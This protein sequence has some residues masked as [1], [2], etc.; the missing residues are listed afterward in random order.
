MEEKEVDREERKAK[1]MVSEEKSLVGAKKG[2]ATFS[3]E[4]NS[5]LPN[6]PLNRGLENGS[7][8][9]DH[10]VDDRE[11]E[12]DHNNND[13]DDDDDARSVV[14]IDN[15]VCMKERGDWVEWVDDSEFDADGEQLDEWVVDRLGQSKWSG[16]EQEHDEFGTGANLLHFE[17][18]DSE[19]A[20]GNSDIV[21]GNGSVA[22]QFSPD[23]DFLPAAVGNAAEEHSDLPDPLFDV[24][25]KGEDGSAAIFEDSVDPG[26]PARNF[27]SALESDSEISENGLVRNFFGEDRDK[28]RDRPRRSAWAVS[29]ADPAGSTKYAIVDS[30][31]GSSMGNATRSISMSLHSDKIVGTQAPGSSGK[32]GIVG[33]SLKRWRKDQGLRHSESMDEGISSVADQTS[34]QAPADPGILNNLMSKLSLRGRARSGTSGP[35][36]RRT[37]S[38]DVST[39]TSED[40]ISELE[41]ISSD[42]PSTVQRTQ[43][44]GSKTLP[45]QSPRRNFLKDAKPRSSL[46]RSSSNQSSQPHGGSDSSPSL[47]ECI[48]RLLQGSVAFKKKKYL[49]VCEVRLWVSE[50]FKALQWEAGYG[51]GKIEIQLATVKKLK[52]SSDSIYLEYGDSEHIEFAF[53]SRDE[54]CQWTS[55]LSCLLPPTVQIRSNLANLSPPNYNLLLDSW[56]GKPLVSRKR[57]FEYIFLGTIGQG[58]FGKVKLAI[59]MKDM[60]FYAV[61]V[62]D[63]TMIRRQQ[64]GSS[65]EAHAY[66]TEQLGL[67]NNREIAIMKKLD[68]PNILRLKAV[69]DDEEANSLYMVLEYMPGG[70]VMKSTKTQ[71]AD[72]LPEDRCR[73]IFIQALS[74]LE[75]LHRNFIVHRDIKPDNLL[76]K[77]DG[78]IKLSDFGT[79]KYY[80]TSARDNTNQ[81]GAEVMLGFPPS[82]GAFK[83]SGRTTVGTPAFL[84]P[85]L[86]LSPLAPRAA[87]PECYSADVWSLGATLFYIVFGRV[88]FLAD[89]VFQMYD[90]ICSGELTFPDSPR[91]SSEL[92]TLLR[93]ILEREP[94]KRITIAEIWRSSWVREGLKSDEY[95][96]SNN[97]RWGET[98]R[99]TEED[100]HS[101]V[102]SV[103]NLIHLN[104]S[105]FAR[106]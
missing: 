3:L 61:K 1:L 5:T 47:L 105:G 28:D 57:I 65:F 91:T 15:E 32:I 104:F 71:G 30:P 10:H 43:S 89:S 20:G 8:V 21:E 33:K 73:S 88:P 77:L 13:D 75:Y 79:A 51:T 39:F 86:S 27:C 36:H 93:R 87:S 67:G 6:A 59:S 16:H 82:A 58:R 2:V 26:D 40:L 19:V 106:T 55:G 23:D 74:G 63:K 72:P 85:E 25:E 48:C 56:N 83:D 81:A 69:F 90:S 53:P 12:E 54:S 17:S 4:D 68:H 92:K 18:L 84:A 42:Q 50:D 46:Y 101:A 96:V 99:V 64:R 9:G 60:K 94:S 97:N 80:A 41:S 31:K 7:D 45:S 78:T 49:K 103:R 66:S 62:L 14:V 70:C 102:L 100:I 38:T 34:S 35:G 44:N 29:S 24:D 37:A 11:D 98:V 22:F 76:C 95:L 52:C